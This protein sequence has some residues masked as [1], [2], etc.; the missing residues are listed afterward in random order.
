MN[1]FYMTGFVKFNTNHDEHGRFTEGEDAGPARRVSRGTGLATEAMKTQEAE[2]HANRV[3]ARAAKDRNVAKFNQNHDEHG[4]F[5]VGDGVQADRHEVIGGMTITNVGTD[6]SLDSV[7]KQAFTAIAKVSGGTVPTKAV[8][9]NITTGKQDSSCAAYYNP[10][11]PGVLSL[12]ADAEDKS[13][14]SLALVHEYGHLLDYESMSGPPAPDSMTGGKDINFPGTMVGGNPEYDGVLGAIRESQGFAD[15]GHQAQSQ[16]D[17][18]YYT[19]PS[20]MFARAYAQYVATNSG[21]SNLQGQLAADMKYIGQWGSNRDFAPISAELDKMFGKVKKDVGG[22]IHVDSLLGS[23]S[24]GVVIR[25]PKHDGKT[26]VVAKFNDNHDEHGRFSTG[27]GSAV[28]AST[29][30]VYAQAVM[31]EPAITSQ[32]QQLAGEHGAQLVG[33]DFRVKGKDSLQ[34]KIAI[35]AKTEH[36]TPAQSGAN[37]SDAVRYTM[38]FSPESYTDGSRQTITELQNKGY[39][40]NVKNYWATGDPY[41]GINIAAISP[42]GQKFELQ[43]HTAQSF[44]VKQNINHPLYEQFRTSTDPSTRVSLWSKMSANAASIPIPN[45]VRSIPSLKSQRL[46]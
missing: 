14:Q 26:R 35:D 31:N 9:I 32:M 22:D 24:T 42:M 28:V 7:S 20:E 40:L 1:K 38:E 16:E 8:K 45:G 18:D 33:L 2:R 19:N 23:V 43:F 37:I 34:R 17:Y 30:A 29:N 11:E 4:R 36:D 15:L 39:D 3:A 41:Q 21:D 10:L 6:K 12:N 13:D 25:R 44:D 46:E 5:D 27:D